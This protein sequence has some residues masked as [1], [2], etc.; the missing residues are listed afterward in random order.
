MDSSEKR[1]QIDFSDEHCTTLFI[2]IHQLRRLY[3]ETKHEWFKPYYE[4]SLVFSESYRDYRLL[5]KTKELALTDK[6]YV[7]TIFEA[8]WPKY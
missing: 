8:N 7:S 5:Y 1:V 2:P 3:I 4:L 6:T